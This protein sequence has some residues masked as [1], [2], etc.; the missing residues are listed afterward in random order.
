MTTPAVFAGIAETMAL[1]KRFDTEQ[2]LKVRAINEAES[3]VDELAEQ[4]A[5]LVATIEKLRLEAATVT[6]TM[7]KL[8]VDARADI[9]GVACH[10]EPIQTGAQDA[11]AAAATI[12]PK[13]MHMQM[14]R[15]WART[16]SA[17]VVALTA[18]RDRLATALI[19][20][21]DSPGPAIASPADVAAAAAKCRHE[22]EQLDREHADLERANRGIADEI[23]QLK[24]PSIVG[25]AP[26]EF[27]VAVDAALARVLTGDSVE[28]TGLDDELATGYHD[29]LTE[30]CWDRVTAHLEQL[31]DDNI[32]MIIATAS[33]VDKIVRI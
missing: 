15:L 12:D 17:A 8:Q 24:L 5:R 29:A 25:L 9:S 4:A 21:A 6:G 18:T 27:V 32:I 20:G 23:Q 33:G 14:S 2:A 16:P 10:N 19:D 1:A 13:A 30:Q 31:S 22:L 28:R 26:L 11:A 3:A 7:L